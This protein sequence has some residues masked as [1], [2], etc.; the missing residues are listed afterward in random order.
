LGSSAPTHRRVHLRLRG[1]KS[2]APTAWP[3]KLE[4]L[5]CAPG[6]SRT[7]RN[8]H[9]NLASRILTET[10]HVVLDPTA[11]LGGDPELLHQPQAPLSGRGYEQR[12]VGLFE[13]P[14]PVPEDVPPG[15]LRQRATSIH[16]PTDDDRPQPS[17][18]VMVRVLDDGVNELIACPRMPFADNVRALGWRHIGVLGI[19]AMSTF[20]DVPA[21]VATLI[22][23]AD[24]LPELLSCIAGEEPVATTYI[25]GEAVGVTEPVGEDLVT[26]VG[27]SRRRR[28]GLPAGIP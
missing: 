11:R 20:F 7:L 16:E 9:V 24:F 17:R 21:V 8:T 18:L 26:S 4:H 5:A 22:D 1:G 15:Q 2:L 28:N 14:A 10:Q 6:G 23:D 3:H 25:K 12:P 19:K 13:F 27:A